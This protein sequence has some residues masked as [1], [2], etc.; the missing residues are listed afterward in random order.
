MNQSIWEIAANTPWWVYPF[1]FYLMHV[2]YRASK[3]RIVPIRQIFILPFIFVPLSLSVFFIH[4]LATFQNIA[5]WF[6]AC[7]VGTIAGWLQ[8]NA[9]KIKA[10]KNEAK[11]YVPGTWSLMVII[12]IIFAVKYYFGFE[13][14]TNPDALL[15]SQ[16]ISAFL[17]LYG[18]FAGLFI[19]RLAYSMRCIKIGPYALD[20][21]LVE[22]QLS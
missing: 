2:G 15:Q 16:Y 10:I 6:G 7:L 21:G 9:L 18:F 12:L 5:I 20:S 22:T 1:F 4:S 13:F 14:S 3:P 19:G 11:L 8:F 17:F